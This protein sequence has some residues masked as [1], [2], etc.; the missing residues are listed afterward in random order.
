MFFIVILPHH[1]RKVLL[2]ENH[3]FIR[4]FIPKG[5][6]LDNYTQKDI[7]LMMDHINSYGR[8][9]LGNRCPYE[10]MEFLYGTGITGLL[11]CHRI[12]PDEVTLNRS[13]FNRE[14]DTDD[15][16]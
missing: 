15:Q 6:S 14:V 13:V 4:M 7:S 3:E 8:A 1:S 16:L 2:K 9:G 10:V 5:T 11:G 12:A